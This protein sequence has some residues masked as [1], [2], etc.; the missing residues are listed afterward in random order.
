M[1]PNIQGPQMQPSAPS[2][3]PTP[4]PVVGMDVLPSQPSQNLATAQMT[5]SSTEDTAS[6]LDVSSLGKGV[7]QEAA[8]APLQP[9]P[10]QSAPTENSN[11]HHDKTTHTNSDKKAPAEQNS[12][13]PLEFSKIVPDAPKQKNGTA[14]ALLTIGVILIVVGGGLIAAAVTG[15]LSN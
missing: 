3:S 13:S 10:S 4:P 8:A 15:I 7:Q 14:T 5:A 9:T 6:D 12:N 11:V 2:G 1:N